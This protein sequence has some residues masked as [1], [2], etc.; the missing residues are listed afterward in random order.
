LKGW[1]RKDGAVAERS[2]GPLKGQAL[3][4]VQE[5]STATLIEWVENSLS[6]VGILL[7]ESQRDRANHA[8]L[9]E[10]KIEAAALCQVLDEVSQRRPGQP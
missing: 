2:A 4:R 6:K 1:V 8:L 7:A 3:K 10:A 5:S 9:E